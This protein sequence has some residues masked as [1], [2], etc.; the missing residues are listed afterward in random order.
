MRDL[1]LMRTFFSNSGSQ[2]I[3]SR[4]VP[5]FDLNH[6]RDPRPMAGRLLNEKRLLISIGVGGYVYV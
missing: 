1:T 4:R 5:L 3:V 6:M 2:K